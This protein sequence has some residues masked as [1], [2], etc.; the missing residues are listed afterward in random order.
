MPSLQL[1]DLCPQVD[2]YLYL[3]LRNHGSHAMANQACRC[4]A[5]VNQA[6]ITIVEYIALCRY[7]Y[8]NRYPVVHLAS[9]LLYAKLVYGKYRAILSTE[10]LKNLQQ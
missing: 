2:W 4:I 9:K 10:M 3:E 1:V 7:P 5:L 8:G 6:S